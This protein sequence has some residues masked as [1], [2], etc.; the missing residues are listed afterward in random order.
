MMDR[1]FDLLASVMAWVG[2][3]ISETAKGA[4]NGE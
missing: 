2:A 1:L 4:I 3:R